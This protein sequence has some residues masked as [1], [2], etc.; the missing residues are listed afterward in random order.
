MKKVGVNVAII[1]N[2]NK[3]LVNNIIE[4]EHQCWA[5]AQYSRQEFLEVVRIRISI[6][7]NLLKA[8]ISKALDKLRVHLKGKYIQVCHRL[9][10]KNRVIVKFRN[11]KECLQIRCIKE[12]LKSLDPTELDIPVATGIFIN[13]SLCAYYCGLWNKCKKLKGMGKLNVSFVANDAI[14]VDIDNL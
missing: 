4:T 10:Y 8:N 11:R 12:D 3:K 1:K 7:I 5:N 14:N 13:E 2:V 9:K 6:T